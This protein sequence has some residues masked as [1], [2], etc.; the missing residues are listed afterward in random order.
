[1]IYPFKGIHPK[2][3]D[4]EEVV[5]QPVDTYS[6]E[7]IETILRVNSK[8]F[9]NIVLKPKTL[10]EKNTAFYN[11]LN[12]G[13]LHED[14]TPCFYIY[15]QQFKDKIHRG[16]IALINLED[17]Q[18]GKIVKHE[19]TL[20]E[21]EE[22]LK[23][24][25]KIVRINAEPILLTYPKEERI[26]A[27]LFNVTNSILPDIVLNHGAQ[28]HQLWIIDKPNEI[29]QVQSLFL[30]MP[31]FYIA[32]GHHRIASSTL[33]ALEEKENIKAQ[34]VMAGLFSENQ[35]SLCEFNR[36]LSLTDD[37]DLSILLQNFEIVEF[38][39]F[40]KPSKAKYTLRFQKKWYAIQL[41]QE[42][43]KNRLENSKYEQLDVVICEHYI[44]K[45]FF[46]DCN[47]RTDKRIQC[48][49]GKAGIEHITSL[50]D[51]S[52]NLLGIFLPPVSFDTFFNIADSGDTMPPK[53]TW[54]AP[55]L[56]NGLIN[57]VL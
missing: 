45:A 7:N 27:Y 15:Q 56:L 34:Y 41:K 44:I 55:K 2:Q 18:K 47:V 28:N 36:I 26:D 14:E 30:N 3:E 54:F 51:Q 57:Y 42:L 9:L 29:T 10:Q 20:E 4:A 6:K 13:L 19:H 1:M 53:S 24:Y 23:E 40:I 39:E 38:N 31:A 35:L 11:F 8:S 46:P 43:L 22:K 5:I 25:L 49:S 37:F 52:E 21:R 16:V 33:L 32:D 12:K 48:I 50:I 17:Y